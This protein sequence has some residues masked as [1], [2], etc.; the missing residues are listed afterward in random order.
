MRARTEEEADH[1]TDRGGGPQHASMQRC[2]RRAVKH[3]HQDCERPTGLAEYYA[4]RCPGSSHF[5]IAGT[6][7]THAHV[8]GEEGVHRMVVPQLSDRSE[9]CTVCGPGDT[10]TWTQE[11]VERRLA[12]GRIERI[13]LASLREVRVVTTSPR[14]AAGMRSLARGS[15][16]GVSAKPFGAKTLVDQEH[17]GVR[18]GT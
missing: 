4:A 12:N 3:I 17:N 15:E 11:S 7:R 8:G 16:G 18:R 6:M 14:R 13:A 10:I 5:L 9:R 2:G 1:H